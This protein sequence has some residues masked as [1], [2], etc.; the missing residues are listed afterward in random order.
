[1]KGERKEIVN[2]AFDILDKDGNGIVEPSD[3][4]VSVRVRVRVRVA[5]C[6]HSEGM[7]YLTLTLTL[8]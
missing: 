4:V 5:F 8:T 2:M 7:G 1:M 6:M 3:L